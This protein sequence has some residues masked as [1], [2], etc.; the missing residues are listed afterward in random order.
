MTDSLTERVEYLSECLAVALEL[1]PQLDAAERGQLASLHPF[2]NAY[3]L[4]G[5]IAAGRSQPTQDTQLIAQLTLRLQKAAERERYLLEELD[6][7]RQQAAANLAAVAAANAAARSAADAANAVAV[8]S[9]SRQRQPSPRPRQQQQPDRPG[10]PRSSAA[11]SDNSH[12]PRGNALVRP[13]RQ[14]QRPGGQQQQPQGSP[15]PH[16][17]QQGAP[18]PAAND[19]R[20]PKRQKGKMPSPSTS[21]EEEYG[22]ST[23]AQGGDT[24]AASAYTSAGDSRANSTIPWS[25]F[26]G[27]DEG[28]VIEAADEEEAEEMERRRRERGESRF[29]SISEEL[30]ALNSGLISEP[31]TV[32]EVDNRKPCPH[33]GRKFMPDRLQRHVKVCEDLKRGKEWRGTWKSPSAGGGSRNN[34]LVESR[35]G[36][37]SSFKT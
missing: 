20:Q 27:D 34:L 15:S 9:D 10:S 1:A 18:A 24:S 11:G 4:D 17:Q 19:K 37:G 8:R 30:K 35:N 14:P 21:A 23:S 29:D 2:A 28:G 3:W 7:T 12:T 36:V 13:P 31:S 22:N 25:D 16:E 26:A 6:E 33:C 5:L 32:H